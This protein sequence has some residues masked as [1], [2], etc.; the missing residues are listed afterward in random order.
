M[1]KIEFH[2]VPKNAS[3][4]NMVEIEIGMMRTQCLDRWIARLA[5]LESEIVIWER[6]CNANK[7][8]ILW[9]FNCQKARRKLAH[10]FAQLIP[11]SNHLS[12]AA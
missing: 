4:W 11:E 7:E 10:A 2:H 8:K 12:A 6:R 3:W 1:R 9:M 5:E